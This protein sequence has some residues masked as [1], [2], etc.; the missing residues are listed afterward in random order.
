MTM[1]HWLAGASLLVL[2]GS[3][4]L[5]AVT[6]QEA[7]KLG[8]EL[9]E[10]GATKAGNADGSIPAYAGGL[11]QAPASYAKGSFQWTDPFASD[12]PILRIDAKNVD[13]YAG[14]LSAG[15]VKMIKDN[16]DYHLNV[17]QSRRTVAY[18]DTV[19]KATV[20]NATG[21]KTLNNGLALDAKCRGGIPFPIPK[22]GYEVMWNKALA[23]HPPMTQRAQAYVVD[24]SGSKFMTSEV[25]TYVE[26]AY[27]NDE[28]SDPNAYQILFSRTMSPARKAGEAT[29]YTDYLDPMEKS[30]RAWSY[31]VGQR[32]VRLAPEF[33][34]DTPVSTLGGVMLYDEIFLFNGA[35][36]RFDYKL[37]GKKEMYV[38]YNAYKTAFDCPADTLIQPGHLNP[39]CERWELH[40]MWVVEATLKPS[41]RHAYS[42]RFYYI[43]E[44]TYQAGMFDSY[45]QSGTLYR[46]GYNYALQ[47]YDPVAPG[48]PGYSVFDFVKG[49]YMFQGMSTGFNEPF[50]FMAPIPENQISPEAIAASNAR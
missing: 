8:G 22:D 50:K 39:A 23:Y 4:A 6:S 15:T 45:D 19:L 10:F 37:V 26:L 24:R 7:A 30:R 1:K 25:Q 47:F 31:T 43:D 38:P 16:A 21:C 33:A 14:K 35:M 20:R 18:P 2:A 41:Y 49:T 36:D 40:R 42:K 9:T 32:R 13:Q 46:G 12:K 44:D 3:P 5:A 27:Y 48:S 29:G 28:R 17:F 34:Y 11:T